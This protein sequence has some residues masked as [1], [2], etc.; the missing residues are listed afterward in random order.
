LCIAIEPNPETFKI[1]EE[2]LNQA[3]H[4]N[5]ILLNVAL[6]EIPGFSKLVVTSFQG[7]GRLVKNGELNQDD[8]KY[9][10]TSLQTLDHI[11]EKYHK[12]DK[13]LVIK[14]DVEGWE[15]MVL[16]GGKD[17]IK[18]YRP[19]MLIEMSGG[20]SLK[21]KIDWQPS[22]RFL[23]KNYTRIIIFNSKGTNQL[24]GDENQIFTALQKIIDSKD[25][26]NVLFTP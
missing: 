8:Y 7:T 25:L 24:N 18:K 2:N 19:F 14:I 3:K 22:I 13:Q 21:S 9:Y 10:N 15:P 1:L 4:K 26:Y 6:A 23:A 5:Y 11:I 16:M 12:I 17:F 20:N